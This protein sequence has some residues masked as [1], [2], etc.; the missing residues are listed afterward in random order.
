MFLEWRQRRKVGPKL[1]V[2]LTDSVVAVGVF[3]RAVGELDHLAEKWGHDDPADADDDCEGRE[4]DHHRGQPERQA[5]A[6][7]KPL[8]RT[9]QR[10]GEEHAHEQDEQDVAD[11][12]QEEDRDDGQDGEQQSE[13]NRQRPV[14]ERLAGRARR[15]HLDRIP[16]K[17][18]C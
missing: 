11:H 3:R 15:R 4:V 1:G 13:I 8:A 10:R 6:P 9:R 14:E 7:V 12:E 17:R 2:R 5:Q 18:R 16:V